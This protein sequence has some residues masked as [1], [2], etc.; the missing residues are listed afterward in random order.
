MCCD[1]HLQEFALSVYSEAEEEAA[2]KLQLVLAGVHS[3]QGR[4]E[5]LAAAA[6]LAA[7]EAH[8]LL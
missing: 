2:R 8:C 5:Y 4:L 7:G 1:E 6:V 3:M